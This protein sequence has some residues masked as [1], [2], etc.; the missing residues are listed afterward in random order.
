MD[1]NEFQ[2]DKDIDPNQLDL[3]CIKQSDRFFHWCKL[4]VEAGYVVDRAKLRLDVTKARLEIACRQRPADF[5][6]EKSTERGV[7]AS[8]LSHDEYTVAYKTWL[9]AKRDCK[10][11]DAAVASMDSKRKMLDNLIRLHGQQ[12][13]AGPNVPRNLVN[14]WKEYQD[15]LTSNVN[16]QQRARTRRRGEG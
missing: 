14:E 15:R 9:E 5:G 2:R 12:Y 11:L 10:L 1:I 8:V 4:A 13:F 3:E 16:T 6:L 7:E